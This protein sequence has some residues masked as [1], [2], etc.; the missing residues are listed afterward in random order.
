ML[1]GYASYIDYE[2]EIRVY[3]GFCIMMGLVQMP[4][5]H[6]Y[7]SK[8]PT[9]RHSLIAKKIRW[10]RIEESRDTSTLWIT[11]PFWPEVT[12]ATITSK[13]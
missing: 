13:E 1:G 10:K 7:W 4:E 9:F 11:D 5:I 6:D 8:D 3:F 2:K 12:K